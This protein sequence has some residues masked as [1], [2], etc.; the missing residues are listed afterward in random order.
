MDKMRL[1]QSLGPIEFLPIDSMPAS[2]SNTNEEQYQI[3]EAG[4]QLLNFCRELAVLDER[5]F[6]TNYNNLSK[7]AIKKLSSIPAINQQPRAAPFPWLRPNVTPQPTPSPEMVAQQIL[8]NLEKGQRE[9]EV[10]RTM[11]LLLLLMTLTTH[12]IQSLMLQCS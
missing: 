7:T 3:T 12:L 2:N 8:N 4:F 6:Y 5:Q 10:N 11:K 9:E 1:V